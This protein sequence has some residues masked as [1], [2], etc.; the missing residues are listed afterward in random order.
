MKPEEIIKATLR[1][2]FHFPPGKGWFYSNTGY[3]LLG[4]IIEKVTGNKIED[5]VKNRILRP[6]QLKN[7]TFPLNYPGMPC[8]YC[9]GYELDDEKIWEDVTVYSPSLL[10]TAGAII[11]DMEDMKIWVKAYTTGITNSAITQKERLTWV[12]TMRGK[13]LKF[14]LGIGNTN[15]WLGYTGGTRGYKH[16]RILSALRGRNRYCFCKLY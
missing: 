8:P 14:G 7:T 12:D 9:H 4:M 6:L 3:I 1:H 10:W 11:S 16:R 15:G 13:H 5:E 2:P